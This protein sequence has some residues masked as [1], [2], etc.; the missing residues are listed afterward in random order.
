MKSDCVSQKRK[1]YETQQSQI[2]AN[3]RK[4]EYMGSSRKTTKGNV[5][6]HGQQLL[7]RKSH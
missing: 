6:I 5:V 4:G 1:Q 2:S 7:S 3:E